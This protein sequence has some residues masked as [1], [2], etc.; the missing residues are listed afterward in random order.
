MSQNARDLIELRADLPNS[1]ELRRI[2]ASLIAA[3]CF[4]EL[5]GL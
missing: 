1:P 2:A 3:G 4:P 5:G